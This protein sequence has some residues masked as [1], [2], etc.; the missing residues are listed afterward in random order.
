MTKETG[1]LQV[2]IKGTD[3]VMSALN[4]SNALKD[5]FSK[6]AKAT[7][8]TVGA[9]SDL[10]KTVETQKQENKLGEASKAA[11]NELLGLARA[12]STLDPGTTLTAITSTLGR[13][14]AALPVPIISGFAAAA[15]EVASAGIAAA[16]GALSAVKSAIPVAIDTAEKRGRQAFFGGG[17]FKGNERLS[18]GEQSAVLEGAVAKF[19]KFNNNFASSVNRLVKGNVDLQQLQQVT[20]GNF[21]ALGTDKGFFLNKIA[22]QFSGLPPS[23]AQELQSQ[24]MDSLDLGEFNQDAAEGFRKSQKG[25]DDT[26]RNA[27]TKIAGMSGDVEKLNRQFNEL[28]VG[29]VQ[30]GASLGNAVSVFG[31]AVNATIRGL[32]GAYDYAKSQTSAGAILSG[33]NPAL[34][35]LYNVV[36][37]KKAK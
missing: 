32:P 13:A 31:N 4:K 10:S 14:A 24:L 37:G 23:I 6:P 18:L 11:G 15:A 26:E 28:R 7:I 12:A 36:T 30:A 29:L 19:G 9:S 16:S 17:A 20:S 25:F 8:G 21:N 1:I 27:Q 35:A 3:I 34:G 5:K 22:S 33:A 2:G